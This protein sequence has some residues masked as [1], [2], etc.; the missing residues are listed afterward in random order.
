[1]D[2]NFLITRRAKLLQIVSN[3]DDVLLKLSLNPRDS[4]TVNTGQTV[5]T[6][7]AANMSALRTMREN[8]IADIIDLDDQINGTSGDPCYLRPSF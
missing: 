7:R 4:F 6:V 8:T 3:I 1:M 5:T 2:A